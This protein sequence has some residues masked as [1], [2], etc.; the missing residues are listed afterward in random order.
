MKKISL[1]VVVQLIF[2]MQFICGQ[3][4]SHD[5]VSTCSKFIAQVSYF[6]KLDSMANNGFRLYTYKQILNSKI[7]N[8]NKSFLLSKLGAPNKIRRTNKGFEYIYYC[9]DAKKLPIEIGQSFECIYIRFKFTNFDKYLS[10]IEEGV[11]DY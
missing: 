10:S 11:F 3:D 7:D 2:F 1:L 5:T 6:W 8:V 9:Y 4:V